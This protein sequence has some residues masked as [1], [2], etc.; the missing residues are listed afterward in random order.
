MRRARDGVQD[1]DSSNFDY[2][3]KRLLGCLAIC[4][5]L[6]FSLE[7]AQAQD[8]Q[9]PPPPMDQGAG[10]DQGPGPGPDQ[11]PPPDQGGAPDQDQGAPGDDQ[12]VSYQ[13]FYDNLSN[14]GTWV[15]TD[16]YGYVFQP[17]VQDPD[18]APYT[19][20]H[21]VY[22]DQGW[23]W[24]SDEP[25]GWATYHYGRWINI[26]GTGWVWVPG[27]RWAPA[28]VSWRYGGGYCGW[29]PLPP[30]TFIGVEFGGGHFGGY[31]YGGDVDVSF[32]IG[33]GYYNFVPVGRM[34]ERNLRGSIVNRNNNFG[35][36]NRTT[37]I[38]NINV[39]RRGNG[40]N[41]FGGVVVNGPPLAE[42]NAHS[43]QRVP[44]MR[45]T[46]ANAP[47]RATIQG[48]SVSVFA[49]RVNSATFHQARP[50]NVSNTINHPTFNRGDSVT[51]PLAVNAHVRPAA[52]SQDVIQ[53]AQQAQA[54]VPASAKIANSRTPV[55]SASITQ[56]QPVMQTHAAA[57][58]NANTSPHV[59]GSSAFTGEAQ[60][61]NNVR[62]TE[63]ATSTFHPQTQANPVHH[64][65][66]ASVYHPQAESNAVHHT[67]AT[68]NFRPEGQ[69]NVVHH[70]ENTSVYHPQAQAPAAHFSE[71]QQPQRHEDRPANNFHA[72]PQHS[73]AVAPH[74]EQ[75]AAAPHAAA[76]QPQAA[77]KKDDKNQQGPG[78]GH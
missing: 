3:M 60:G 11:G 1:L 36:I 40:R 62:H 58:V 4:T 59:N 56:L 50:S 46:A 38:T 21:W 76:A 54:H 75:H 66:A 35:I 34:G 17:A 49:P 13:T 10:P 77:G 19:D 24:I 68:S 22:T 7:R 27:Y 42:I 2:L 41:G 16:D 48:N 23:T 52:P 31:H 64:T 39:G 18:W 65:E 55:R 32:H 73:A 78:G 5:L 43:S 67:E 69:A 45:L 14:E 74:M 29:A 63:A 20:G 71:N 70:T 26:D 12:G 53:R 37:N 6:T 30:E 72:E 57:N 51:Q 61:N 15:Q 8:D 28:W 9:A 25:W 33:A 47:G 44:T